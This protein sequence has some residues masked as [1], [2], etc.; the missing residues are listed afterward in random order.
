MNIQT[1][2]A[3]VLEWMCS[4]FAEEIILN[5]RER[6]QRFLEEALELVQSLECTR[7]EAHQLVD[8]VFGRPVGKPRSEVGGVLVTLSA[9]CSAASFEMGSCWDTELTRCWEIRDRI[10]ER[11]LMKPRFSPVEVDDRARLDFLE[12]ECVDMVCDESGMGDDVD[13]TWHISFPVRL[14]PEEPAD[15]YGDTPRKAIDNAMR[16]VG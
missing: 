6:N 7:A 9:L 1:L 3:R 5:R 14:R 13:V 2:Q 12:G 8:Y 11:Q 10:Q 4:T 16:E 15:V